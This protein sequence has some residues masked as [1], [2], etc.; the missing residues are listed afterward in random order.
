MTAHAFAP[1]ARDAGRQTHSALH[2]IGLLGLTLALGYVIFLAGT[3]WRGEW[4]IDTQGQP[5][6]S[7]FVNVWAAGDLARHG[8]APDAYDWTLHRLAEVQ[9]LGH[10]FKNYYGWHYPPTFLFVAAA[11][12]MLPYTAA[13]LAWSLATLCAYA[14]AIREIVGHPAGFFV[15]LGFPAVLWNLGAGQNGSLTAALIGGALSLMERRPALAGVCLGLLTYKPQFGLLFPIALIA[16]ARWRA[17]AVASGVAA[18]WAAAS[19]AVFGTASWKAFVDWM[20]VTSRAVLGEGAADW[21]RMQSVFAFIRVHG[22]SE[23]LAWGAQTTLALVLAGAIAWLWRSRADFEIKAAALSCAA[24]LATPYIYMYDQV[25]LAV[26]IAFLVRL[27]LTR[28]FL[29]SEIV[30]L[31]A[32]T[33][34]LLLTP[35]GLAATSIVALLIAQRALTVRAPTPAVA[36]P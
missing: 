30:G 16:G 22:G 1:P 36:R 17:I 31:T 7:D 35:W 26:P 23:A 15:A 3:W 34:L 21:S 8:R 18:I 4:L 14:A 25:A 33:A 5:M 6:A 24:L 9:A 28:G 10:E 20:P 2:L 13:A 29:T 19:V 12:A 27:A 32:A 11:I